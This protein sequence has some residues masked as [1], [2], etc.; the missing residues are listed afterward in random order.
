MTTDRSE[1]EETCCDNKYWQRTNASG[2]SEL[3]ETC[4]NNKYWQRT[5]AST[6]NKYLELARG[7]LELA[8]I[9]NIGSALSSPLVVDFVFRQWVLLAVEK[10]PQDFS[11]LAME[12]H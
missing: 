12:K 4:C 11:P 7:Y 10:R 9:I 6:V 8:A 1:L 2:C 5:N 3:E